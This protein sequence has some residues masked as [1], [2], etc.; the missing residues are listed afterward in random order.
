M[1]RGISNIS[2]GIKIFGLMLGMLGLLLMS[3]YANYI[4]VQTIALKSTAGEPHA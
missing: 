4:S 2:I 1:K 3:S